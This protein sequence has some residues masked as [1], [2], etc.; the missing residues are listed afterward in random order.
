MGESLGA[1]GPTAPTAIPHSAY[2]RKSAQFR[3]SDEAGPGVLKKLAE[4]EVDLAS[5]VLPVGSDEREG[6][7]FGV[8]D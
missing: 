3:L 7:E 2:F 1:V 4:G 5:R 6:A 8:H